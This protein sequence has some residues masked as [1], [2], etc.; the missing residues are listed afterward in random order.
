MTIVDMIEYYSRHKVN[1]KG[2][3]HTYLE[4]PVMREDH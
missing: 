3:D 1:I 4:I 2:A